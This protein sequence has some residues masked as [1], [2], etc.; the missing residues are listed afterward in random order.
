MLCGYRRKS[1]KIYALHIVI[2]SFCGNSGIQ[3]K[4]KEK[5]KGKQEFEV[6]QQSPFF[7]SRVIL[8][9][10]LLFS[11]VFADESVYGIGRLIPKV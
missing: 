10:V 1:L 11:P 6:E 3:R 4:R 7:F 5:N 2:M 9:T 8:N